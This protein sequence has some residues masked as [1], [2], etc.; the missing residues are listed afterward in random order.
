MLGAYIRV[1]SET[2]RDNDSVSNQTN[3]A[4]AIAKRLGSPISFY[5]DVLSGGKITRKEW[6]RLKEDIASQKLHIVWANENDRLGRN[7]AEAHAFLD[8]LIKHN[9]RLFIGDD[10]VDPNDD[11]DWLKYG[12]DSLISEADRRKIR[13]KTRETKA[14][15]INDGRNTFR[16]FYGYDCK[17]IGAK[18]N[19]PIRKWFPVK[20]EVEIIQRIYRMYLDEKISLLKIAQILNEEGKRTKNGGYWHTRTLYHVLHHIEYTGHTYDKSKN[21]I[22]SKIYTKEIVSLFDYNRVQAQYPEQTTKQSFKIGRP[23]SHPA[24][25]IL[26]CKFCGT[27]Y[28]FHAQPKYHTYYHNNPV[29]CDKQKNMV[30][31]YIAINHIFDKAF[32]YAMK[33]NPEDIFSRLI[34]QFTKHQSVTI[35]DIKNLEIQIHDINKSIDRLIVLFEKTGEENAISRITALKKEKKVLEEALLKQ[36]LSIKSE[37]DKVT[38]IIATFTHLK[39]IEYFSSSPIEKRRILR[40]VIE[41]ATIGNGQIEISFIDGRKII[42]DYEQEK[43]IARRTNFEISKMREHINK[44]EETTESA[45]L[46]WLFEKIEIEINEMSILKKEVDDG[47]S[48]D[49]LRKL[50]HA[51]AMKI[52]GS[53]ISEQ[54]ENT[55]AELLESVR[56]EILTISPTI[57]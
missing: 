36:N 17:I 15:V 50:S 51:I 24:S 33:T 27:G 16:Q 56:K 38:Q 45:L 49:D 41:E 1:S 52:G 44:S 18:R 42:F 28:F 47:T 39:Q 8:L 10:E 26:R 40:S 13:K 43:K 55:I 32:V 6:V 57:S 31:S 46:V 14:L 20:Q 19:R 9:C 35:E 3:R 12:F 48:I 2:Q 54:D 37:K 23:P 4:E 34:D 7:V 21:I 29:I 53:K 11:N 22:P 30:I 5:Y 25:G